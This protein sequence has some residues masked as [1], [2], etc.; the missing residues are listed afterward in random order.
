MAFQSIKRYSEQGQGKGKI[1][2]T[3]TQ[4]SFG[5][6]TINNRYNMLMYIPRGLLEKIGAE[7]SVAILSGDGDDA[8]KIMITKGTGHK[9]PGWDN[10]ENLKFK[11]TSGLLPPW[12]KKEKLKSTTID[13][14][15]TE[16]GAIF[17]VPESVVVKPT[18]KGK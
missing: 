18:Q 5:L 15:V 7:K 10:S 2:L 1:P 12:V 17:D 11:L 16:E 13:C 6:T 9:I 14:T 4:V 3:D 8:G